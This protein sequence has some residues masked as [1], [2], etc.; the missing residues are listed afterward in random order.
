MTKGWWRSELLRCT[1]LLTTLHYNDQHCI[2]PWHQLGGG[3][4]GQDLKS[5]FF[6]VKGN[7]LLTGLEQLTVPAPLWESIAH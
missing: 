6:F 2:A 7:Q 3:G 1:Y 4:W 5:F